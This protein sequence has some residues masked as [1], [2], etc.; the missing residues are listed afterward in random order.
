MDDKPHTPF[1][2]SSDQCPVLYHYT[3]VAAALAMIESQTFWLSEYTAMNDT[4]EFAFAR[5]LYLRLLPTVEGG[6]SLVPRVI[7]LTALEDVQRNMTMLI[8]SLTERRD[9]LNQWRLYADNGGGCVVG[10]DASYLEHDAGVAIRT[11]LYDE[12]RVSR[13]LRASMT[14]LQEAYEEDPLDFEVSYDY[15]R[16]AIVDLFTIKHPAFADEREVRVSR[17]LVV[18]AQGIT[19]VGGNRTDGSETPPIPP[20]ERT[21]AFGLTRSMSLPLSKPSGGSA[22]VSVGIGPAATEAD[23]LEITQRLQAS[24]VDAWRSTLPFRR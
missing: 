21:G 9:D 6:L 1:N 17:M 19:D 22:I 5:E 2:F 23:A 14:V 13:L 12:E 18:G 15:A 3:S 24:G 4:S 7:A 10:I 11:V 8:G 16:R 20:F